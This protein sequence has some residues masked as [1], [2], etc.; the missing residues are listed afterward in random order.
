MK[1]GATRTFYYD[2]RSS[3]LYRQVMDVEYRSEEIDID[4]M[5][6]RVFRNP[7]LRDIGYERARKAEYNNE[8]LWMLFNNTIQSLHYQRPC[9]N[10]G[11]KRNKNIVAIVTEDY[12]TGTAMMGSIDIIDHD[13]YPRLKT[14]LQQFER[15]TDIRVR[16]GKHHPGMRCVKRHWT[17][18]KNLDIIVAPN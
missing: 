13:Q 10:P 6:T 15:M 7:A 1:D 14:L 12:K 16:I 18:E 9:D 17:P 3:C 8:Q 11:R 4:R 5:H 2:Q